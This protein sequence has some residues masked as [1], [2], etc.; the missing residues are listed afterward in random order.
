MVNY[1]IIIT[2]ILCLSSIVYG[3]AIYGNGIYGK[4]LYG[5][6]SF[7]QLYSIT[8]PILNEYYNSPMEMN[9]SFED[10]DGDTVTV[11]WYINQTLNQTTL[12]NTTFNASN[13]TYRLDVSLFDG[14]DF[15]SNTTVLVFYIGGRPTFTYFVVNIKDYGIEWITFNWTNQ[16]V[17]E[18]QMSLDNLSNWRNISRYDY[19]LMEG[20]Q[21]SLQGETT[22]YFRS[23]NDSVTSYHYLSQ[24]TKATRESDLFYIYITLFGVFIILMSLGYYLQDEWFIIFSGM[25]SMVVAIFLFNNTFENLTNPYLKNGMITI[26]AGLGMYL[27]VVPFLNKMEEEVQ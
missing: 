7:P 3:I 16:S 12:G 18:I 9:I 17:V 1:F 22:Y 8:Q 11:Y 27:S 26:F 6:N 15:S 14:Y 20:Y 21:T 2:I 10:I 4:A 24:K 23:K 13:S 5:I 25:L 19:P